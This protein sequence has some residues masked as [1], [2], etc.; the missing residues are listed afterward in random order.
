MPSRNDL[1]Q[2]DIEDSS[3]LL[4]LYHGTPLTERCVEDVPPMPDRVTIYQQN[5]EAICD[6]PE[7]IVE[8]VRTTVLHEI[9]HF[10][11]LD[12]EDLFDVG[13]E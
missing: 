7:E 12:E 8:Q 13:Y 10:F 9:G 1:A 3:E 5:I 2:L 6:S 11:G 4:G